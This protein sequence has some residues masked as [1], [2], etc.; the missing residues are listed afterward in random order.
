MTQRHPPEWQRLA[1]SLDS[2]VVMI[3]GPSDSGK[4]TLTRY[5]LETLVRRRKAVAVVDCDMGQSTIGPPGTLGMAYFP[6]AEHLR[7]V[8]ESAAAN[9]F[10]FV[11]H[12]SPVG[13]LL[14]TIVGAHRLVDEA[15]RLGAGITLVDTT[16]L[17][18]GGIG[19][20]LKL[21]KAALLHPRHVVLLQRRGELEHLR[22]VFDNL[23]VRVH[24]MI[25]PAEAVRRD[26]EQRRAYRE[27]VLRRWLGDAGP[28]CLDFPRLVLWGTA[29]YVG[30]PVNQALLD[31]AAAV[32]KAEVVY[33]E[34]GG[35]SLFLVVDEAR[36]ATDTVGRKPAS[37]SLLKELFHVEEVIVRKSSSFRGRLVAL[38]GREFE[39][40]ALAQVA[41]INF[42]ERKLS[43]RTNL[44]DLSA[45]H[46]VKFGSESYRLGDSR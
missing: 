40:L 10:F 2:G 16:G 3:V 42:R 45:V 26:F 7:Q 32:L 43:V 20:H 19:A 37:S 17:V 31:R 8:P 36:P 5:L 38:E 27:R 12:F 22:L 28:R 6:T 25:P 33:G 4:T 24:T 41:E 1:D 39:F 29:H 21:Q 30:T 18:F 44:H 9:R 23:G 34:V 14:Q 11:G 35:R 13:H 46:A 15:R